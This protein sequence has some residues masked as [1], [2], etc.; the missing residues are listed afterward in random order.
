MLVLLQSLPLL[1]LLALLLS[2]RAGPVAAAGA[3]L[4]AAL[5]GLALTLPD[6]PG[7][8]PDFLLREAARAFFL[9]MQPVAVLMGGLLFHMAVTRLV[10]TQAAPQPATPR[11]IFAA[12]L[13]GGAFVESVTG[14]GVGAAFALAALR[15][16][17]L[18]GAPAGAMALLGLS[19]VPWGGLGP[20]TS[21]GAA[22]IGVPAQ[23]LAM[24]TALPQALWLL[25]LPL[26]LWRTMAAAGIAVPGRERMAQWAIML[27]VAALLLLAN[28]ALPF[29]VAGILA[30]GLP[31]LGVLWWL[32]PPRGRA[33]WRQ[34]L[35]RL[36]PWAVL[37]VALLLARSWQGAPSWRPWA[38]LPP[39][40][41]TH[42]AVVLWAVSAFLLALRPQGAGGAARA[43]LDRARRPA[44]AMLLYVLLGRWLA[45][46]GVAAALASAAAG[47][48]G[49]LAA[50][51]LPPLGLVSGMVTGSN[52]ASNA[53][54]MPVQAA[55]G[56]AAGLPV[57]LA[58]GLHNFSG[59]AAAGM[60][61]GVTAMVVALLADGTRPTAVWRLLLPSF[62]AAVLAGWAVLLL[63]E[64]WAAPLLLPP[65]R[66]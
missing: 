49:P 31:L 44:L 55:L 33:G 51:A 2:G 42:V 43:A 41:V 29:E 36:A 11:R 66:L 63:G 6:G 10:P 4:L 38:E 3:A 30:S 15:R 32:D 48:L 7:T 45:G 27:A 61:F 56:A 22:L 37:I 9:G 39:L 24:A 47:V 59:A 12:T 64:A 21:L 13:L 50:F 54:L 28:W 14:F 5:P 52:V 26:V 34:A 35:I 16:M 62:V 23:S 19:L 8:T 53:A 17:G 25:A 57:L 1:L 60:S 20:G 65:E 46:A 40:P 18:G 58:A